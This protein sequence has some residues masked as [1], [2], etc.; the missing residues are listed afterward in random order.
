V[1]AAAVDAAH[2]A[3]LYAPSAGPS[4]V[5]CAATVVVAGHV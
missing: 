1:Y 4:G 2:V 5:L 3:A